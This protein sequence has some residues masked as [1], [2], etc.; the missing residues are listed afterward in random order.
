[1]FPPRNQP[2]VV[3]DWSERRDR[4]SKESTGPPAEALPLRGAAIVVSFECRSDLAVTALCG[5]ALVTWISRDLAARGRQRR[6]ERRVHI[7]NTGA[8]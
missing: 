2:L 1:M 4:P 3:H 8:T 5:A 7:L 6:A